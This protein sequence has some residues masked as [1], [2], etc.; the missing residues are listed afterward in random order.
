[1]K[2]HA[3]ALRMIWAGF[4]VAA[5][6][7]LVLATASDV[8]IFTLAFGSRAGSYPG[9]A[10]DRHLAWQLLIWLAAGWVFVLAAMLWP[11]LRWRRRGMFSA[12]DGA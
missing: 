8:L 11:A 9:Q 1:M 5:G 2:A 10:G 12:A 3:P 7:I 4:G 6:V